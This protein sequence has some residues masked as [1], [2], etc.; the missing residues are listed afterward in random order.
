MAG[1]DRQDHRKNSAHR[2]LNTL[3]NSNAFG[4]PL[5]HA[6]PE[7]VAPALPEHSALHGR[8]CSVVPLDVATHAEALF[9]ANARAADDR[10]W[11][12]L[13]YG[14]FKNFTHYRDWLTEAAASRDPLYYTVVDPVHGPVGVL[15]YMR[16]DPAH[17]VIEIGHLAFSPLLQRSVAATETLF[18]MLQNAFA[19]GY[20]RCEWKCNALNAPSRRA[21]QRLGFS[22]EGLFRQAR[23]DKG[24]SRDTAWYAII[25]R[26]WPALK[27]AYERWLDPLN[28]DSAGQQRVALSSLTQPL[29]HQRG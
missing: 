19:L 8:H 15:S 10:M 16:L 11:T 3:N 21:A 25:D 26:E 14:P 27:T 6:L 9:A 18:L 7:W 22:F 13:F 1:E 24:H 12:Y 23:V 5:G 17:G 29:L 4:Q 28:F 2:R 20:R